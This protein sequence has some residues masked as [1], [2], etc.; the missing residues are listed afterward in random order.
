MLPLVLSESTVQPFKYWDDGIVEGMSHKTGLYSQH[1]VHDVTKRLQVYELACQMA[2][3]GI[4]T[5]VTCSDS[6]YAIWVRLQAI[7]GLGNSNSEV[8][9]AIAA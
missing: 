5:C 8:Y 2:E 4:P 6:R 1:S 7:T 3:K 9:A